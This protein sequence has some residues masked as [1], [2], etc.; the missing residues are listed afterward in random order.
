MKKIFLGLVAMGLLVSSPAYAGWYVAGDVGS[1][2]HG[3]KAGEYKKLAENTYGQVY[4]SVGATITEYSP[5]VTI[6]ED[7]DFSRLTLGYQGDTA[8]AYELGQAELGSVTYKTAADTITY[9]VGVGGE[10]YTAATEAVEVKEEV[11]TTDISAIYHKPLNEMMDL[12]FRIG[13]ASVTFTD[14][15]DDTTTGDGLLYGIGLKV[16]NIRLEYQSYDIGLETEGTPSYIIY[17]GASVISVGY[18]YNF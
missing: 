17:D 5:S 16:S 8:W 18:Q 9:E 4:E 1:T 14:D 7:S 12:T 11:S 2:S 3:A 10:S 6:E 15:D 13:L